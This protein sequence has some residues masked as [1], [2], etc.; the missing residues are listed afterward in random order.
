M[1][2]KLLKLI[3]N[4]FVIIGILV[5][6]LIGLII[7][8]YADQAEDYKP[9][10]H[11]GNIK[12][13]INLNNDGSM[14]IIETWAIS[15]RNIMSL[16]KVFANTSQYADIENVEVYGIS[17]RK[18]EI[19]FFNLDK[20]VDKVEAEK[21]YALKDNKNQLEIVWGIEPTQRNQYDKFKL[22]YTVKGCVK[23]YQDCQDILW[24][25]IGNDSIIG[26][27]GIDVTIKLPNEVSNMSNIKTWV[28]GDLKVEPVVSKDG[29]IKFKTGYLGARQNL[30]FRVTSVNENIF[31]LVPKENIN[32]FE[33]IKE[34]EKQTRGNEVQIFNLKVNIV[35]AIMIGYSIFLIWR[36]ARYSKI[37]KNKQELMEEEEKITF[38]AG[39]IDSTIGFY[40]LISIF[41]CIMSCVILYYI[42]ETEITVAV[43]LSVVIAILTALLLGTINK[44]KGNKQTLE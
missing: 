44:L 24:E 28:H 39:G 38:F 10:L 8:T 9:Y 33:N 36:I 23:S 13:D 20:R 3:K 35:Y 19:Q 40:L 6:G 22:C 25:L 29:L 21:Y 16:H 17:Q 2:E 12:Y 26:I 41:V 11:I 14:D 31:E 32:N 5:G 30:G 34:Q 37:L 7:F 4:I 27:S 43:W 1:R 42:F 18:S 15:A